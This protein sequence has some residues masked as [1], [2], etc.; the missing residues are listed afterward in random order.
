MIARGGPT[1]AIGMANIK[2]RRLALAVRCHPSTCVGEYVPFNFCPRSVM[3]FVIHCANHAELTYRGGQGPIVHLEA[4][5]G[6]AV[7]WAAAQGRQWAFTLQN[8]SAGYAQFRNDLGQLDE[9]DWAAVVATDFRS[10]AVKEA[11]QAEFLVQESFPWSLVTRVGV[12]SPAIQAKA[13]AA[14]GAVGQGPS[15]VVRPAWYF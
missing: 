9:L 1:G 6:A 7:G 15:V 10:S 13:Q 11:K 2:Q 4:D 5:L 8:A 3:L 14:I 12:S